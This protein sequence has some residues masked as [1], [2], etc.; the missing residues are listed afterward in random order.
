M[1]L[2]LPALHHYLHT[3]LE[4]LV[5][6]GTKTHL[7]RVHTKL[8]H[9]PLRRSPSWHSMSSDTQDSSSGSENGSVHGVLSPHFEFAPMVSPTR[10]ELFRMF[11]SN[12][13]SPGLPISSSIPSL[14]TSPAEVEQPALNKS[15]DPGQGY[16]VSCTFYASDGTAI[17][18]PAVSRLASASG[19][20]LRTGCVC[21]PGGAAALRGKHIQDKMEELSNF[22]EDVEL[23]DI[24]TLFSGQSST[25]VVRLSLGMVSNFED[26]WRVVQW[27][28][29]LL[30]EHKRAKDLERL[31][32]SLK[33]LATMTSNARSRILVERRL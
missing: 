33:E 14:P 19:I 28:K 17:P 2:R 9:L 8:R 18:L 20:S 16:V 30:D 31:A 26:V 24:W 23:K 11:L 4:S 21:N 10:P 12:L 25:G 5:Y 13:S 7:V 1:S 6:P 22:G 15:A 29:G 3:A 27:A 32:G